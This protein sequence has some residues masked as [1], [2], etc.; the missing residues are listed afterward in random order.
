VLPALGDMRLSEVQ[1]RDVQDLA[2][3]LTAEGLSASTVF[4]TR[5]TSCA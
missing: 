2:D 5:S 1:R 3:R 4:R